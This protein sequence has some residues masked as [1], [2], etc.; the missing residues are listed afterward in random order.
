MILVSSF[1]L[2]LSNL[3]QINLLVEIR[4]KLTKTQ[5]LMAGLAKL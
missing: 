2:L 4:R 5:P 1:S 3:D